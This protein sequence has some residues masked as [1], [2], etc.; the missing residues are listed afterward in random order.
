M[1]GRESGVGILPGA[2]CQ[3]AHLPC[4][5][6]GYRPGKTAAR[7]RGLNLGTPALTAIRRTTFNQVHKV[8]GWP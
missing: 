1:V 5:Q 4:G 7:F 8:T 6:A 3:Q 2:R